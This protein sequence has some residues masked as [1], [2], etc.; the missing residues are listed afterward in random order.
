MIA[1]W[2]ITNRP[3]PAHIVVMRGVWFQ[4]S[5]IEKT[6]DWMRARL[7]DAN[8]TT[9]E[10]KFFQRKLEENSNALGKS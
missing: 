7:A 8:L 9:W 5:N 6:C 3:I 10:R 4:R 1:T 2:P